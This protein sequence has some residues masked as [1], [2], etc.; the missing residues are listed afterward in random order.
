[1]VK[2]ILG[3]LATRLWAFP[4]LSKGLHAWRGVRFKDRRSVFLGLGVFLDNRFPELIQIG[5]DVWLTGH[6][7]VLCHSMVSRLQR[8]RYGMQEQVAGVTLEDGVFVG[9]GSVLLPGTVLGEGCYVG[10]RSVVSGQF[11]PGVLIAGVPARI[12]RSLDT[13]AGGLVSREKP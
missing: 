3:V 1:M 2:G 5:S 11:P 10:A 7:V 8:E 4:A 13:R 6:C 12:I 9:V